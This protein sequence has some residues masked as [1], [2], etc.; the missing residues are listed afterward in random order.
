M[1][2]KRK[3]GVDP[4]IKANW[5]VKMPN[6][7]VFSFEK[8]GDAK[9]FRDEVNADKSRKGLPVHVSPGMDHPRFKGGHHAKR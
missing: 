3:G 4:T 9:L 8:K 5:D 7:D 2:V 1:P 6:G